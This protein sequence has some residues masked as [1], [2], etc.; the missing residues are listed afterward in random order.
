MKSNREERDYEKKTLIIEIVS[1]KKIKNS[2][3][4]IF[5]AAMS[6]KNEKN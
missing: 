3:N 5:E 4:N 2:N 6:L 1:T